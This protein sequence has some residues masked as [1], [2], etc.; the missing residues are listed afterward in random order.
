MGGLWNSTAGFNI[1]N[2]FGVQSLGFRLT[3]GCLRAMGQLWGYVMQGDMGIYRVQ[4][5]QSTIKGIIVPE[6]HDVPN[7]GNLGHNGPQS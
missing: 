6:P 5:S 1:L 3:K 2:P 7:H 4:G